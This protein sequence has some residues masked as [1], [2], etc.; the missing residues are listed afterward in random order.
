MF[1]YL[2]PYYFYKRFVLKSWGVVS[3]DSG[4]YLNIP[5]SY[6]LNLLGSEHKF[7]F[8]GMSLFF[9]SRSLY[10]FSPLPS[11]GVGISINT[12]GRQEGNLI[13]HNSVAGVGSNTES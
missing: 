12:M 13:Q 3:W 8:V 6:K 1:C 11:L 10:C 9:I 7:S 2:C 5:H 4:T